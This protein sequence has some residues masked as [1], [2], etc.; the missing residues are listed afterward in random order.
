MAFVHGKDTYISVAGSDL[1]A[2]CDTSELERTSDVHDVTTFGKSSHV[3]Q[4]GLLDGKGSISGTYDNGV[5]GPRAILE[6]LIGET[7]T[8]VR[9]PAGTGSGRPQDTASAVVSNYTETNAV[10]DMIKWKADLEV[11]D[12]VVTVSQ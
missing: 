5:A 6:P 4:G 10:A 12:G 3:K 8:I 1:S 2:F 11:S 9:R 7:V